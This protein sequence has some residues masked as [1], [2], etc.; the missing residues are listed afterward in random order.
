LYQKRYV[1]A[2]AFQCAAE[3]GFVI[4]ADLAD[5]NDF[6]AAFEAGTFGRTANAQ[7]D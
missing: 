4:D 2:C 6:V 7:N 1:F 3:S 5:G